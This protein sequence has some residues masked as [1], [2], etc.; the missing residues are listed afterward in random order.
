MRVKT[1]ALKGVVVNIMSI[2]SEIKCARCD[3]KYSGVRSRCPY[4][5]ARRIGRG[6]YSED[7]DNA[8]GKMLISVLIMG[9]LV[10]ASGILLFTTPGE[11][12]EGLGSTVAEPSTSSVL[13][14]DTDVISQGGRNEFEPTPTP[15]AE[16]TPEPSPPPE[17]RS[18]KIYFANRETTDFSMNRGDRVAL[19]VR[20]EPVG[21]DEEVIWTSSNPNIFDV[22][23]D[24]VEGT[25]ATVTAIGSGNATLRVSVGGREAECIVRVRR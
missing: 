7:S 17:V 3:R 11:A 10:V 19:R 23:A 6:K 1:I 21:L 25:A 12:D 9:V 8:K 18:V 15:T 16:P 5:G 14:D 4:C 22:V 13:P 2:I 20:I 24:S